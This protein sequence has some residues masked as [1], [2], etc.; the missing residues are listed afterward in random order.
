M[1]APDLT[2]YRIVHRAIRHGATD[3]ADAA[4]AATAAEPA[5]RTAFARYW[6]GYSGE[7]LHHHSVE[8]EIFFP[9]L[10]E[11]VPVAVEM[12]ERTDADHHHLDELMAAIDAAVADLQAVRPNPEL[13]SLTRELDDHMTAHLDFED[14]DILPLLERHFDKAEY[15]ALDA[16][17]IKSAGLGAQMMFSLPMIV[18]A[19]TPEERAVFVPTAPVPLRVLYRVTKGRHARLVEQALG[20]T[21][22]GVA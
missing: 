7:V 19:M 11:R 14:S 21:S 20:R 17:A 6:K 16:R 8:D 4:A 15:D 2:M 18:G 9:A 13:V 22:V 12:V 5:R 3:I 1:T 10:V